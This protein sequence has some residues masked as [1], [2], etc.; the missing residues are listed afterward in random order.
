MKQ[1]KILKMTD[2]LKDDGT[3]NTETIEQEIT[4]LKTVIREKRKTLRQ[5]KPHK[6]RGRKPGQTGHKCQKVRYHVE[7]VIDT[8][9]GVNGAPDQTVN[10]IVGDYKTLQE[11]ADACEMSYHQVQRTYKQQTTT[12]DTLII[13]KL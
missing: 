1:V 7:R 3:V 12:A 4:H 11:I 9:P 6:K 13:T 8:I 10:E 5:L 2:K